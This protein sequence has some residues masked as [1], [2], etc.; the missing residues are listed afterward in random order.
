MSLKEELNEGKNFTKG[1]A[2]LV[3]AITIIIVSLIICIYA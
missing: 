2:N 1:F 3:G